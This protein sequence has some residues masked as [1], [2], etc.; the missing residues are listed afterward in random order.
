ML[1]MRNNNTNSCVTM[2]ADSVLRE[3]SSV[4]G[5]CIILQGIHFVVLNVV[6]KECF[7]FGEADGGCLRQPATGTSLPR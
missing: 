6:S 3:M 7:Q 1:F 4:A 5:C 2:Q